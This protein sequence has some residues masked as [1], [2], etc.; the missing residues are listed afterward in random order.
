MLFIEFETGL[1]M[2]EVRGVT[3]SV[4]IKFGVL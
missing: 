3:D 4:A 2:R 1:E